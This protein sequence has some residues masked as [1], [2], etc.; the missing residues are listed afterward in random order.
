MEEKEIKEWFQVWF[1]SPYYPLL[2]NHRD[3]TEAI[4]F[5]DHLVKHLNP[6]SDSRMLD[7]ACGRGRHALYLNKLGFD[8]TG[9]DLSSE[10]I[11]QASKSSSET[12]RFYEHDMRRLL[13]TNTYHF[14][15]NLFTSFG[16]F[17]RNHENQ[18]VINNMASTLKPGGRIIIDFL[19]ADLIRYA[20]RIQEQ[21]TIQGVEFTLYKE[22]RGGRIIK[23]IEVND[24]GEK[25]HFE[26]KVS[27]LGKEEFEAY[28]KA[29]NLKIENIF[30][31]YMLSDFE[32]KKS[33][34]LIYEVSKA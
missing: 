2:Y 10:S 20:G 19:N 11:R 13:S 33:P 16:Y 1:D 34:R 8:V 18:L 26:E 6:S 31:N 28:F 15:F 17:E 29:A 22:I 5:L 9:V 23:H 21:K 12:L 27:L 32:A 24:A 4:H 25:H 3:D 30:G 7:L 14:V